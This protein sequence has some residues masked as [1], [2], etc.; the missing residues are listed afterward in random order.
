MCQIVLPDSG[1]KAVE[2]FF[3]YFFRT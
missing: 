3:S 1:T 2:R